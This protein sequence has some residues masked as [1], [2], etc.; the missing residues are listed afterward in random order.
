MG[1]GHTTCGLTSTSILE[2]E[3]FTFL[4]SYGAKRVG[5][6]VVE[7]ENSGEVRQLAHKRSQSW[8]V[9]TNSK[10]G[11]SP[12]FVDFSNNVSRNN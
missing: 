4:V 11:G 8:K 1:M 2:L 5:D 7:Y 6:N 12:I 3:D 10:I 9:S